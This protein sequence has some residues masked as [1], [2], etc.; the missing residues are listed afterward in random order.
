MKKE[1]IKSIIGEITC[2]YTKTKKIVTWN[3]SKPP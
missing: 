1:F 2:K 3:W